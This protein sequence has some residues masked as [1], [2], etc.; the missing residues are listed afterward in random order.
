MSR[1]GV[2]IEPLVFVRECVAE[3]RVLWTYHVTMRMLERGISREQVLA[4][5]PSFEV[6][7]SYPEDKYLPSY[8]VFCETAGVAFHVLFAADV[9]ERNVRVVT[10]YRPAADE[11]GPS[12]KRR[13][14]P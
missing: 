9:E 7:E 12:L 8:L 1:A 5:C 6:I 3:R 11:W 2:P 14:T 13:K 10:A 4:A